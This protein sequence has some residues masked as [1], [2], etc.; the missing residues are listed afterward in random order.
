[1]VGVNSNRGTLLE[2]VSSDRA[3][4]RVQ[5]PGERTADV[6]SNPGVLVER[7]SMVK[8]GEVHSTEQRPYRAQATRNILALPC[9]RSG[10]H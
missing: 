1:M 10:V 9:L 6:G 7:V 5:R 3:Q 4:P 2:R 8:V